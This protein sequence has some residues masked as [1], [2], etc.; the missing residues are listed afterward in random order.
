VR[1]P[2][3]GY[4]LLQVTVVN[5]INAMLY[6]KLKYNFIRDIAPVASI[7]RTPAVMEVNPAFPAK[8]VREFITYAKANP[9]KISLASAGP[10]SGPHVYGELFKMMTGVDLVVVHYRGGAPMLTDLISG[11]V[12]ALFD[13]LPSSI[14]FIRGG[15]LRPLG[16]TTTAR[17]DVLPDVPTVSEFVPGYEA[18]G[19]QG[20]GARKRHQPKSSRNSTGRSTRHSPMPNSRRGSPTWVPRCLR[21]HLKNLQRTLPQKPRSGARSSGRRTSSR[22]DQRPS[23]IP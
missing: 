18:S 7:N 4:T 3:D 20:I 16:V 6:D 10:G 13:P 8:T 19:W 17:L 12:Q 5:A 21:V 14:G 2:P 1:S 15:Q 11:Q 9:G 23:D 22:S